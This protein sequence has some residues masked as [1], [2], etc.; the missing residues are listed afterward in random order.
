MISFDAWVLLDI[1]FEYPLKMKFSHLWN[2]VGLK[3]F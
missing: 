3:F 1:S 2:V